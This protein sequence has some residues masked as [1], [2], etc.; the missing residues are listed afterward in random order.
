MGPAFVIPL[1]GAALVV[2]ATASK[3]CP[4]CQRAAALLVVRRI[5]AETMTRCLACDLEP[6]DAW[7]AALEAAATLA[8]NEHART[9]ATRIRALKRR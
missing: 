2:D 3:A 7:N 4:S 1:A 9:L 8:K 6:R 5:G